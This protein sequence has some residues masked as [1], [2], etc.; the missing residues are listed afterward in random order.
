MYQR[1][2]QNGVVLSVRREQI[3]VSLVVYVTE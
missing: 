1:A 3:F 2:N